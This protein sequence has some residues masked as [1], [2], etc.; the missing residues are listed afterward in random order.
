MS[1]T[2]KL[3]EMI[4]ASHRR[5]CCWHAMALGQTIEWY[6]TA[7]YIPGM[8]REGAPKDFAKIALEHFMAIYELDFDCTNMVFESCKH[9][10]LKMLETLGDEGKKYHYMFSISREKHPH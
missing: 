8:Y 5:W 6:N 9:D 7:I 10:I 2:K 1:K 4:D 3:L